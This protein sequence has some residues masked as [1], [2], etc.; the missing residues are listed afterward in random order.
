MVKINGLIKIIHNS[1]KCKLM[2][3]NDI[4]Y[5]YVENLQNG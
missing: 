5:L 3:I 1:I 2:Q 4:Y